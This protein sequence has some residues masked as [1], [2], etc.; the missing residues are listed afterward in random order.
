MVAVE[1]WQE[2]GFPAAP[3]ATA[4]AV[5][6]PVNLSRGVAAREGPPFMTH[7]E[8]KQL[9]ALAVKGTA[10]LSAVNTPSH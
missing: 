10:N 1:P 2:L 3:G 5:L 7:G 9:L 4:R 8:G 6:A